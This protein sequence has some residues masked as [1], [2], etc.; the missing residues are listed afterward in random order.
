LGVVL[1]GQRV[2]IQSPPPEAFQPRI[3][4]NVAGR[5]TFSLQNPSE[6][7]NTSIDEL[8][9]ASGI[10]AI[11]VY[12]SAASVPTEFQMHAKGCGLIVIWTKYN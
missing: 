10:K 6:G 3:Q 12:P 5:P 1:D 2:E 8:V 9:A 7:N 4:A 11:E